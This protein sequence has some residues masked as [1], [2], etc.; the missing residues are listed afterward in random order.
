MKKLLILALALILA[1][2]VA[3]YADNDKT[4]RKE[5]NKEFKKKVKQYKKEKW[6]VMGSRTLEVSLLK[7]YEKLNSIDEDAREVFGIARTKTKNNG[8]Q[9]ASNNA[10]TKY[11]SDAGSYLKGRL[12]SDVFADGANPDSEFDHFFGAYE[13]MLE[14]EIKGEMQESFSMI[15]DMPDGTYE[16]QVF[17][18][19]SENAAA[20]ARMRALQSALEESK[21]AQQYADQLSKFVQEGFPQQ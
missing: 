4:L 5:L 19:V 6:S 11:A 10:M 3:M 14:K 8:Y 21:A 18:V 12:V 17:Y 1:A 16:V 20:K 9:S 7:H 15:R 2:P 13:R